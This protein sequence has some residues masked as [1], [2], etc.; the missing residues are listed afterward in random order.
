[1]L[2]YTQDWLR[3]HLPRKYIRRNN[4]PLCIGQKQIWC[5]LR[6]LSG[7]SAV[8]LDSSPRPEFDHWRWIDFREP[9]RQVVDFKQGVYQ[10]AMDELAPLLAL[11]PGVGS[12]QQVTVPGR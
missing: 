10:Q 1:M 3:Y 2:G 11:F 9:A 12:A 7:D 4:R 6:M 5:L 8:C